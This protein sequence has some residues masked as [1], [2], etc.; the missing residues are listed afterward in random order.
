MAGQ[1]LSRVYFKESCGSRV[2]DSAGIRQW[3]DL[4]G[5]TEPAAAFDPAETA[6]LAGHLSQFTRLARADVRSCRL[7]SDKTVSERCG[8][9]ARVR[10]RACSDLS[11]VG[12]LPLWS[13]LRCRACR[14]D[15]QLLAGLQ[16]DHWRGAC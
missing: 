11:S 8:N 14:I 9:A 15:H 5:N 10:W 12:G 2:R 13:L 16:T 4:S 6:K 7:V 1:S 3:C